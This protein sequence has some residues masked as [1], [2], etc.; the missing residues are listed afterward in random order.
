M[1]ATVIPSRMI[2]IFALQVGDDFL[3]GIFAI[4][5]ERREILLEL[6]VRQGA[7]L[8]RE[9]GAGSL[10]AAPGRDRVREVSCAMTERGEFLTSCWTARDELE[11]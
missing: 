11:K 10:S 4:P 9:M 5:F 3:K 2:A 6:N 8:R 1:F 7:V